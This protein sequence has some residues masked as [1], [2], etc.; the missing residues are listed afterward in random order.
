MPIVNLLLRYLLL[1]CAVW[2]CLWSAACAQGGPP[3]LTNDPGTPGNAN[4]E[5]NIGALPTA[6]HGA[7]S[8]QLPQL[9][10]NFGVGDRIQLTYEIPYVLATASGEPSHTGWSNAFPGVKWRF[11][12]Q[13]DSGWQVSMF[14]QFETALS[15][16]AQARGLGQ[17]GSR[18]LL[19][20]EAAHKIGPFD[21][22]AEA[23]YYLPRGGVHERIF[24]LVVGRELNERFEM[25]LEL[26]DDRAS[27]APPHSTTLDIG[28]RYKLGRSFIALFMAGRSING[29]G[30]D[31]PEFMGYFGIQIL[32]S[33][34]GLSLA[35]G[36]SPDVEPQSLT[37]P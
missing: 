32:L 10:L 23:G 30:N 16:A 20:L 24:G 11:L 9:D 27:G 18:L 19:P 34:Y 28:G 1:P 13:G 22:D 35:T 14:P 37:R 15:S 26:Y 33:N 21:V 36:A 12:D 8:Y 4:W 6:V 25:D 5:I 31:Q 3:Y 7:T 29:T 17:P 2:L